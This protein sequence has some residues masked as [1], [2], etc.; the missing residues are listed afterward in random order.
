ME[1]NLEVEMETGFGLIEENFVN[2]PQIASM[3]C[4]IF[5]NLGALGSLRS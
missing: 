4:G 5:L 2:R 3:I 1:K